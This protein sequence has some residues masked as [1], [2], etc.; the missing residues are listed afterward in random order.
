MI[1]DSTFFRNI[2]ECLS[3]TEKEG[4]TLT[5]VFVIAYFAAAT[6]AAA[7]YIR[8]SEMRLPTPK[9]SPLSPLSPPPW[10]D[11][12]PRRI[13]NAPRIDFQ[14]NS[15]K[16]AELGQNPIE[17]SQLESLDQNRE[18]RVASFRA[19]KEPKQGSPLIIDLLSVGA[20]NIS[21]KRPLV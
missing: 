19:Q 11:K 1:I 3:S 21:K 9:Y 18:S 4:C 12:S 15:N 7:W 10:A 14:K 8:K 17:L 6:L 5:N 20:F 16:L 2:N 13:P